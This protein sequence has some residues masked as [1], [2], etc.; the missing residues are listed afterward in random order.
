MISIATFLE[1]PNLLGRDFGPASWATWKL[2]LRAGLGELL[3]DSEAAAFRTIASRDPPRRRVRELWLALGRRSGKD[4]A[5]SAL[6]TYLAVFSDLEKHLRRG[7]RGVVLCLAVDKHQSR[8]VFNY[9][10]AYFEEIPLLAAMLVSVNDGVIELNNRIDIV[11]ATNNYRS[12]RGRTVLC[13][14]LD[15]CSFW[16]DE[17]SA[18]PDIE[19]Y[20]ALVPSLITLRDSGAMIVGISS[21]YRRQGLLY[22]KFVE[23]HGKDDDNA[24]FILAPS[25]TFN[26]LLTEPGAAAEIERSRALDPARAAAEWDSIWR[27]DISSLIDPRVLEA[28]CERGVFERQYNSGTHYVG[29]TDESG[30]AGGDASTLSICH[31]ESDGRVVQDLLRVWK[32]PFKPSQVIAEK[33]GTLK[34]YHCTEVTGDRWAGGIPPDLYEQHGIKYVQSSKVTSEIYIDFLHLI[35]SG[36]VVLLDHQQQ[37]AELLNLERRVSFGGREAIGHPPNS[38]D[39]AANACAG[40]CVNA[41]TE[42]QPW[43][44]SDELL[45]QARTPSRYLSGQSAQ[46]LM[47]QYGGGFFVGN[48]TDIYRT[49]W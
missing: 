44:I 8:L 14:I 20:S 49:R 10:R 5:A 43:V 6:A 26:P 22:S 23:H 19:V 32:P 25:T 18:N 34:A 21:V 38:H 41:S 36:R 48:A 4:S 35:N 28:A 11:V 27:D 1:D 3:S 7:E 29:F 33:A 46:R 24:L 13:A 17:T 12:I 40:A 2:T 42:P 15:E 31:R 47:Q 9:I 30:G 39:D 37:K 16:R 45:R